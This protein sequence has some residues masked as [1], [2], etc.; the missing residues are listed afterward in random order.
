[1]ARFGTSDVNRRP[2][3]LE[4]RV[5]DVAAAH[6]GVPAH[7]AAREAANR[8]GA[9]TRPRAVHDPA[10]PD[11]RARPRRR[12]GRG[13]TTRPLPSARV[14][15]GCIAPR[16]RAAGETH[17]DPRPPGPDSS[18]LPSFASEP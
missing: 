14:P 18:A 11:A 12:P 1:M 13:A 2:D 10:E 17:G 9:R 3:A 5:I 4:C 8:A 7:G 15:E 16:R 6:R